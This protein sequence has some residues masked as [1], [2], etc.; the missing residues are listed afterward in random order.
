MSAKSSPRPFCR[1]TKANGDPCKNRAAKGSA[2]CGTHGGGRAPVGRPN[3]L[4]RELADTI[5]DKVRLGAFYE[6]AAV[7]AGVHKATLYRWREVGEADLEAG[8]DTDHAYFCDALMRASA[9]AEA[10]AA[11]TVMR[12]GAADWRA[13][14]W[15]LERR[16]PG[17]WGKREHVEHSGGIRTE[18]IIVEADEEGAATEVAAIL[19]AAG[20]VQPAKVKTKGAKK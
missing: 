9:D 5:A 1:A 8:K 6:D 14:A 16:N 3:T 2:M 15:Y 10:K 19:A 11:E 12:W 4:T 20:A 7:S 18:P 17:R 13:A